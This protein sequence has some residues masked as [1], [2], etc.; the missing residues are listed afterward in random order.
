MILSSFLPASSLTHLDQVSLFCVSQWTAVSSAEALF[1]S[2]QASNWLSLLLERLMLVKSSKTCG[3]FSLNVLVVMVSTGADGNDD[4]PT[5]E[6]SS[7]P[8]WLHA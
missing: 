3:F 2:F 6:H 1:S 7:G 4:L 5:L 8:F